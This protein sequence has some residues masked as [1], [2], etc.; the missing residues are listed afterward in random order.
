MQL[1]SVLQEGPGID[2][3][4]VLP[5]SSPVLGQRRIGR[6]RSRHGRGSGTA[7]RAGT[8]LRGGVPA[9]GVFGV[10]GEGQK[11]VYVFDR[12][13]S[14]DGHGGAPLAAA[15]SELIASLD[16]LGD[17]HQF[18]IIFYNEHPHIFTP[19]ACR[20]PGVGQ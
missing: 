19:T 11:F 14:M 12:S 3:A 4:G 15:K 17:T 9:S 5:A 13:G 7:A 6:G 10:Q 18:Q 2:L 1:A 8:G 20:A 16:D